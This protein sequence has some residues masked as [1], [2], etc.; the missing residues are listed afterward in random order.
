MGTD[1]GGIPEL[2]GYGSTAW[3][4]AFV[5]NAGSEQFYGEKNQMPVFAEKISA[6]NL[7]LIVRW[8][9]GDYAETEV[10]DYPS[11]VKELQEQLAPQSSVVGEA[12]PAP[13]K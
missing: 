10:H 1:N 12:G 13:S 2:N 4:K 8:M 5:E 9:T 11:K 7:D 6:K 3:L